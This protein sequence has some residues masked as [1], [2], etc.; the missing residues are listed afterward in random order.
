MSPYEA[1]FGRTVNT[2]VS[3]L[4]E[5]LEAIKKIVQTNI[6]DAQITQKAYYDRNSKELAVKVCDFVLLK[7]QGSKPGLSRKQKKKFKGP[8]R[9]IRVLTPNAELTEVDGSNPKI[10][11]MNRLKPYVEP[12]QAKQQ[13][14][15]VSK[16][17]I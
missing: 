5:K 6:K 4:H 14:Q 11:H 8:F 7:D 13:L 15:N 17:K 9:V 1:L 2:Y 10:V 12:L 3:E 16:R